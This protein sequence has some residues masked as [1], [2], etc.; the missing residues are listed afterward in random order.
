M[1]ARSGTRAYCHDAGIFAQDAGVQQQ[2]IF[3]QYGH[4]GAAWSVTCTIWVRQGR[5]CHKFIKFGYIWL[6]EGEPR[7]GVIRT[8][9]S[10]S[11]S[12]DPKGGVGMEII[13][14]DHYEMF[15]A[16]SAAMCLFM[17]DQ[18]TVEERA[19][20]PIVWYGFD[21]PTTVVGLL[22]ELLYQM[23]DGWVFKR[24]ITQKLEKVDE[25][26]ERHR[27]KQ[28]KITGVAYGERFD[29]RRHRARFPVQAVLLPRLKV[30]DVEEGVRLYCVLDA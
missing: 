15:D 26:D 7:K 19:E 25:L 23:D 2:C 16:A 6:H 1:G 24:F 28:L 11:F 21:I 9:A 20:V 14:R 12:E 27:K 22:S 4:H 3:F 18:D 17:W 5:P 8:M 30:R 10:Y 13:A 29:A